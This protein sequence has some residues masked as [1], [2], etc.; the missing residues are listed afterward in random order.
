MRRYTEEQINS[1][2][3]C[4]MYKKGFTSR[5]IAKH[6]NC[7]KG[8]ILKRLKE[9]NI[10][11]RG[12]E[13]AN[14]KHFFNYRY[15]EKIDSEEKAYILGFIMA[16]G[17]VDRLMTRLII[18]LAHIDIDVLK[19]ISKCF[20]YDSSL[21]FKKSVLNRMPQY[22]LSLNSKELCID[23]KNHGVLPMKSYNA[24]YPK[25]IPK[26]LNKDFISG[27]FDGD[28]SVSHNPSKKT[29]NC[30]IA[31][32]PEI[33]IECQ[34]ILLEQYNFSTSIEYKKTKNSTTAI[35]RF[36][37]RRKSLVFYET[38][39]KSQFFRL[40]RKNDKFIQSMSADVNPYGIKKCKICDLKHE[41]KG[42]CRKHL[43]QYQKSIRK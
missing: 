12:N 21:V 11:A 28:G 20:S 1:S 6:F 24:T 40:T 7:D 3:V 23:L 41:S 13:L 18:N 42:Y 2:E 4:N 31:G 35:L 16:D 33:I 10:T 36:G 39:Y 15:L 38:I 34:K 43:Y 29:T 8:C 25:T 26:H 37:G 9:N 14:R 17:C 5:Q 32:T 19:F 22:S 27:L 30:S